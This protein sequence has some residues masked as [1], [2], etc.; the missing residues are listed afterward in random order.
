M[1]ATAPSPSQPDWI[2]LGILCLILLLAAGL[3]FCDLEDDS[4]WSDEIFE[5]SQAQQNLTVVLSSGSSELRLLLTHFSMLVGESEFFVRLPYALVGIMGI[6]MA[7]RVGKTLFDSKTGLIGAFLLAISSFHIRYSQEARSYV[8]TVLLVLATLYYL[9][10]ALQDNKLKHWVGFA[11]FTALSLNNYIVAAS[12]SVSEVVWAA[13]ILL[14]A[15][16]Y[17]TANPLAVQALE[18]SRSASERAREHS[19]PY[20]VRSSRTAMLALSLLLV[21]ILSLPLSLFWLSGLRRIEVSVVDTNTDGAVVSL[22][23]DYFITLLSQYG[24]GRG[25][26]L[27][28]FV[29]TFVAGLVACVVQRQW[30]KALLALIWIIPPFPV[31]AHISSTAPFFSKHLIFILP[32]YLLLVARGITGFSE[33]IA[34]LVSRRFKNQALLWNWGSLILAIGVFGG[35]SVEPVRAYYQRPKTDWRGATSFLCVQIESGDLVLQAS[36]ASEYTT[37]Y[38]LENYC[39]DAGVKFS[40]LFDI[41]DIDRADLS[42]DIWWVLTISWRG[43]REELEA[44]LGSLLGSDFDFY[45]FHGVAIIHRKTSIADLGDFSQV[46]VKMILVQTLFDYGSQRLKMYLGPLFQTCG[47]S[48][49]MCAY[50]PY[51]PVGQIELARDQLERGRTWAARAAFCEALRL[52]DALYQGVGEL[53]VNDIQALFGLSD[54]ALADGNLECA[55]KFYSRVV[56]AGPRGSASDKVDRWLDLARTSLDAGRYE[57][58]IAAYQMAASQKAVEM[59]P[60]DARFHI[61]LARAYQANGQSDEAI[62]SLEKATD[63]AMRQLESDR[64]TD[65]EKAALALSIGSQLVNMKE[66]A[67]AIEFLSQVAPTVDNANVWVTLGKAYMGEGRPDKAMPALEQALLLNPQHYWA[68]HLLAGLYARRGEWEAVARLEQVALQVAA[69]DER[70]VDSG[71]RL[72]AAYENLGDRERACTTLQQIEQW[73]KDSMRVDELRERLACQE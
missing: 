25:V 10:R 9:W 14:W 8:Y 66:M 72:V 69:N 61:R 16:F 55:F 33:L 24:A 68:N 28:L 22:S 52:H 67:R 51:G 38:Y 49:H 48:S 41:E 20:Q 46:G 26:V 2:V 11:L 54:A 50:E 32:M 60:D 34:R 57:G 21:A 45:V 29:G 17:G 44:E 3:R 37:L 19:W 47:L 63:L 58:A 53:D 18:S 15:R 65:G 1:K 43:S 40:H 31:I 59:A 27:Y 42:T 4:L 6:G 70:R 56:D 23:A 39:P 36:A 7:Y 12:V 62:A 5:A 73:S 64:L 30:R 13:L 71:V 35:S